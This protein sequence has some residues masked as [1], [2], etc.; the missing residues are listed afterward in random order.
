ME[1]QGRAALVTGGGTG[2]GRALS[3]A[4]ARQGMAVAVNYSRSEAEAHATAVDHASPASDHG[5]LP[6]RRDLDQIEGFAARALDHHRARVAERVG[7]MSDVNIA[8]LQR[9]GRPVRGPV[10]VTSGARLGRRP[11]PGTDGSNPP[12]EL[13]ALVRRSGAWRFK[14]LAF[15]DTVRTERFE[16]VLALGPIWRQRD[17]VAA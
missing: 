16:Q 7:P 2:L 13:G 12:N 17:N 15:Q 3:L 10:P 1:L 14:C 6:G 8:T 11:P 4:L 9:R 5:S